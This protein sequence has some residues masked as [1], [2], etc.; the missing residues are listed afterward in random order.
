M[1]S[2]P[3]SFTTDPWTAAPNPSKPGSSWANYNMSRVVWLKATEKEDREKGGRGSK[4]C[5][6]IKQLCGSS[7]Q[8]QREPTASFTAFSIS[9]TA[10]AEEQHTCQSSL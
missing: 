6:F 3:A 7:E 1:S 5:L 4:S 10:N 2:S 9:P 8:Q